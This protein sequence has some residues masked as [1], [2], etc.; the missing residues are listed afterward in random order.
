MVLEFSW[1]HLSLSG[2]SLECF[3]ARVLATPRRLIRFAGASSMVA[4]SASAQDFV[5][6]SKGMKRLPKHSN[7]IPWR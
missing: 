5:Q 7:V 6:L 2:R 4:R 3:N 1:R